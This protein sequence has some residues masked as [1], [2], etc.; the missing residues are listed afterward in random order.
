MLLTGF[1]SYGGRSANPAEQV[2][3]ALDGAMIAGRRVVART[4]PVDYGRLGPRIADLIAET[5]PL[6]VI[7]L[8]LWPGEP[9]LRLE[10]IAANIADFEIADN[11]GVVE[12]GPVVSAGAAAYASTLPLHAIQ[13][14]LLAVGIP[15]RLSGS[16]GSFLCNALMYHALRICAARY[17]APR[18]GLIHVPYLPRQVAGIV[19]DTRDEAR[20][21]LHQRA[22]L[23]SMSLD[24]VVE[25]IRCAIETTL[26]APA[27]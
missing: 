17:P 15:A 7:C 3:R 10:R 5:A 12:R 16:A 19:G 22:D 6:A 18:C 11:V 4:L 26:T 1:E 14:R 20:F 23:A 27:R 13:D 25:G 24:T 2:V 21:E 9:M 8:G